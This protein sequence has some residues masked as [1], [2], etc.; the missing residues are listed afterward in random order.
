MK[1]EIKIFNFYGLKIKVYPEVYDPAE[2]TFHLLESVKIK[3]KDF[4]LELGCG[5]GIISLYFA[6]KNVNLISTDI[7]PYAVKNTIE[8]YE[9]NKEKIKGS[10]D[11]RIGSLFEPIKKDEKFDVIIFN[12]PYLPKD[13]RGLIDKDEWLDKAVHG[14]KDGLKYTKKF[15]LNVSKYLKKKGIAYFVFSSQSDEKKLIR[16]I[17]KANLNYVELNT[18]SFEDEKLKIFKIERI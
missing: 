13:N 2:D 10:F 15:I 11:V 8:N 14:G 9:M 5:C 17:K 3:P 12:P 4:L 7:N 18:L 1:K 6:S 16:I